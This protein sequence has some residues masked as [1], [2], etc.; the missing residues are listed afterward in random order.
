LI[1]EID[2]SDIDLPNDLLNIFEE[3]GFEI[4]EL[5]RLSD[6]VPGRKSAQEAPTEE[7]AN[8]VRV[9]MHRPRDLQSSETIEIVKGRVRCFDF[10]IVL[11]TSNGERALPGPFLRR[12][13]RLDIRPP[14]EA[15]LQK[16]IRAHFANLSDDQPL[17]DPVLKLIRA[18]VDRRNNP[19]QREYV[20]TDQ[21]M[22]AVYLVLNGIEISSPAEA[23]GDG[24]DRRASKRLVD[25]ILEAIGSSLI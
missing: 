23:A 17:P 24:Q 19:N 3:G 18:V 9:P 13:L 11:L 7:A 14:D 10:P 21:L 2:K 1:D 5:A 4:P 15:K 20:A 12:C 6:D 25:F 22:N 8:R 16:I